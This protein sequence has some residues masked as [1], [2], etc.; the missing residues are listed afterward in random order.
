M[1]AVNYYSGVVVINTVTVNVL[2][3]SII[4]GIIDKDGKIL[5]GVTTATS[6]ITSLTDEKP[7]FN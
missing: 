7:S 1:K 5:Q 6:G 2:Y 4:I 3:N